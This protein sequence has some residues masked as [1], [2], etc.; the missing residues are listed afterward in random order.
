M[1]GCGTLPRR[2]AAAGHRHTRKSLLLRINGA[3][4]LVFALVVFGI[5]IATRSLLQDSGKSEALAEASLMMDSALAIRAYTSGEIAPLLKDQLHANFLPQSVPAYAATQNLVALREA[6]P[7]YSY[8]EATLNP[9]NLRDRATDWEADIIQKFRDDPAARELTG[10]RDGALGR[11]LY[12]ARPV[13]A[14]GACLACHS[15]PSMAPESMLAR[16]GS[17]HG[18]GWQENEVVAAQIVSV[19]L[20]RA[21]MLAE[22]LFRDVLAW[23]V[24]G[25][26]VALLAINL[27]LY[28]VILRPVRQMAGVF[29]QVSRGDFSA[30]PIEP[31]GHTEIDSLTRAFNRLRVSLEKA[32][33]MIDGG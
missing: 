11:A 7:D 17:E 22:R 10:E 9:T 29:D 5:S 20:S 31:R 2:A 33:K 23:V 13:R 6:H 21:T 16:Y 4:L 32:M 26:C 3:L 12:L 15:V 1:Y 14:A 19:P 18:F 24:T 8:K 28:A 27:V 30:P 25:F